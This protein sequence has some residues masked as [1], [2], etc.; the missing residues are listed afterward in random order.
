MAFVSEKSRF[1]AIA[2]VLLAVA[3][4][5]G[6]R[7]V[8]VHLKLVD[9]NVRN[10]RYWFTRE[11]RGLRGGIYSD[12]CGRQPFACSLPI[13]EYHVDPQSVNLKLKHKDGTYHSREAEVQTVA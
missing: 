7:L 3:A 4:C 13:W 11:V 2:G 9:I 5:V 10:P 6:Y 1:W 8:M 12:T